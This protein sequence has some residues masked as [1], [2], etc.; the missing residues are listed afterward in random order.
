MNSINGTHFDI[1]HTFTHTALKNYNAF[2]KCLSQTTHSQS[3][4]LTMR[5]GQDETS[6]ENTNIT[7]SIRHQQQSFTENLKQF[8]GPGSVSL[9]YTQFARFQ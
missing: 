2:N 7:Q 3:R 1:Q 6:D 4:N 5:D 8:N 9:A